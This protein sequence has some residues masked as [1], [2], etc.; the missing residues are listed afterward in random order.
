[1]PSTSSD[2]NI[3]LSNTAN[4]ATPNNSH[5]D[6]DRYEAEGVYNRPY[7]SIPYEAHVAYNRRFGLPANAN[8]VN[9]AANNANAQ[10]NSQQ[11]QALPNHSINSNTS[12][13]SAWQDWGNRY[14]NNWNESLGWTGLTDGSNAY[15]HEANDP[16]RQ[17]SQI[18]ND[19]SL[20]ALPLG[21]V[22]RVAKPL[23]TAL[24]SGATAAK[25]INAVAPLAA[26]AASAGRSAAGSGRYAVD[27]GLYGAYKGT[28]AL[29]G[30]AKGM[31]RYA[32]NPVAWAQT[33]GNALRAAPRMTLEG[34]IDFAA[35]GAR[36]LPLARGLGGRSKMDLAMRL[37]GSGVG[38]AFAYDNYQDAMTDYGYTGNA[39]DA[40][41]HGLKNHFANTFIS[42]IGA[43]SSIA[44][45]AA[46]IYQAYL[47]Q[48]TLDTLDEE[49]QAA[50]L[51]RDEAA[52]QTPIAYLAGSDNIVEQA[53]L[54]NLIKSEVNQ[55]NPIA[56]RL[57]NAGN[58]LLNMNPLTPVSSEQRS[59]NLALSINDTI[60]QAVNQGQP[61][62]SVM[63][64][65]NA[66]IQQRGIDPATID[67]AVIVKLY[68]IYLE[69]EMNKM[70]NSGDDYYN[71][72]QAKYNLMSQQRAALAR[73]AQSSAP[74]DARSTLNNSIQALRNNLN[75][76]AVATTSPTPQPAT[77]TLPRLPL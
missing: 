72:N 67:P 57:I 70:L 47:H 38:G 43:F 71:S 64:N 44:A 77:S 76:Q 45:S 34:A 21:A 16:Y 35:P 32:T 15:A 50:G 39:Y 8:I 3:K 73:A 6:F 30:A 36:L 41:T 5:A 54:D 9:R 33:A 48:N 74:I 29:G 28:Q 14:A 51:Y 55:R 40:A 26:R 60:G 12:W 66:A 53:N 2:L 11:L 17:Y 24:R 22:A 18:A 46:P 49:Q 65:I 58:F 42:P 68:D 62:D 25:A 13:S 1:M 19:L 4:A 10:Q 59:R 69:V 52:K 31:Y 56:S 7:D 23:F 20:N 27:L 75:N 61:I 63:A 37:F